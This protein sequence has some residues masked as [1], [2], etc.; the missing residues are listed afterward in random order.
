MGKEGWALTIENPTSGNSGIGSVPAL[1]VRGVSKRYLGRRRDL[2][3][4]RVLGEVSLQVAESEFFVLV[5]PSGCGKSTLLRLIA[6]L[7]TPSEK[8]VPIQLAGA[9]KNPAGDPRTV[10]TGVR[11]QNE[12]D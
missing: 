8:R 12:R 2:A 6:G 9:G 1:E 10:G 7:D 11:F 5:G 3:E 4:V